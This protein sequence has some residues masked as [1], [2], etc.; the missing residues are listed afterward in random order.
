M[1]KVTMPKIINYF[2]Y[3]YQGD[4]DCV[5]EAI[6][7]KEKIDLK[8][9]D[10]FNHI[11]SSIKYISII[12]EKY[13]ENFK[14][15][16]MPPLIIYYAGNSELMHNNNIIS[17][18]GDINEIAFNKI[19]KTDNVYAL[20]MTKHNIDFIK[21]KNNKKFKFIIVDSNSFNLESIKTLI[22]NDNVLYI[23]EIPNDTN[24]KINQNMERLLLGISKE[25][26]FMNTNDDEFEK[27]KTISLFEKRKMHVIGDIDE[28]YLANASKY[29]MN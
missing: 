6:A 23:S 14:T 12:D 22:N 15:I 1:D 20:K 4:W 18:F 27:Y 10:D 8:I 7:N 21:N 26:V 28:K 19:A 25:S 13:P 9:L 3:K 24:G 29:Q 16:Y 2:N 5:Y 11:D 17:L